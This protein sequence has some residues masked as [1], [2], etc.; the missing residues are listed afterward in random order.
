MMLTINTQN[1]PRGGLSDGVGTPQDRW[2][3]LAGPSRPTSAGCGSASV[4][5]PQ[6]PSMPAP[7]GFT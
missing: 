4:F 2:P 5:R 3:A 1:L 6:P 7:R